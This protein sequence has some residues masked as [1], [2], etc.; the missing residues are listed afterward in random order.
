MIRLPSVV[1]DTN[2]FISALI[3]KGNCAEILDL[4]SRKEFQLYLNQEIIDE[5]EAVG[6]GQF[7]ESI[8]LFHN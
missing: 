5:I 4:W 1:V 2:I 7:L 6:K 8:F 3:S